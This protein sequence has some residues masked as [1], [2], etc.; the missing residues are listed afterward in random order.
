M[1][2]RK[3]KGREPQKKEKKLRRKEG[4]KLAVGKGKK[5]QRKENSL[6]RRKVK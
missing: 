1:K 4:E 2:G 5:G 6:K 3:V